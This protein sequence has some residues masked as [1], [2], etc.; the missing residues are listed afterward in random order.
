MHEER[1]IE[2]FENLTQV[3]RPERL[4]QLIVVTVRV[5][6]QP[7][8]TVCTVNDKRVNT[9]DELTIQ[10]RQR[11]QMPLVGVVGDDVV[12]EIVDACKK[13]IELELTAEVILVDNR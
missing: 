6:E 11:T 7:D 4:N 8:I 1:K 2:R 9:L 5:V 10:D 13:S 3:Q 12:A